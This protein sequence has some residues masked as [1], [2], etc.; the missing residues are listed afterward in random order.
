[1]LPIAEQLAALLTPACEETKIA[2]SVRRRKPEV[3]DLEF[4]LLPKRDLDMFGDPQESYT[5]LDKVIAGMVSDRIL[6]WDA[7]VKRNGPKLKRLLRPVGLTSSLVVELYIADERNFG[8]TLAIRTGCWE[9][10]RGMMTAKSKGG[11]M[12]EGMRQIDGY[13]HHGGQVVPCRTEEEYFARL[14]LKWYEPEERTPELAARL[15]GKRE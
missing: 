12:P 2:G 15:W 13:L 4:V 8:N 6:G 5:L 11:G 7:E 9:F 3:H 10:S 1:M 14:G